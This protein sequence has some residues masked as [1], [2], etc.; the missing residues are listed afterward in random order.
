MVSI[1]EDECIFCG[2]FPEK[3]RWTLRETIEI[4]PLDDD[5]VCDAFFAAFRQNCGVDDSEPADQ[6]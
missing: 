3:D 6:S 5:G 4:L 2:H 1:S